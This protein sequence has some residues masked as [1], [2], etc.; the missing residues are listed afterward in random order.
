MNY[1]RGIS[2]II[3]FYIQEH[4]DAAEIVLN[5]MLKD[6]PNENKHIYSNYFS[7]LARIIES[8]MQKFK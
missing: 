8:Y 2:N 4:E 6:M 5:D 1:R 7:L 3:Y